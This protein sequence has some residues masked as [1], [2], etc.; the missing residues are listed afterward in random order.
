MKKRL[1]RLLIVIRHLV[2]IGMLALDVMHIEGAAH[3]TPPS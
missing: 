3:P 1:Q 2:G